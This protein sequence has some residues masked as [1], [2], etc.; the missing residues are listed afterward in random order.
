MITIRA[1]QFI[2]IPSVSSTIVSVVHELSH[3]S[4]AK[5]VL[6]REAIINCIF[7]SWEKCLSEFS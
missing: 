6:R 7:T 3:F 1:S 2:E 5:V 4:F